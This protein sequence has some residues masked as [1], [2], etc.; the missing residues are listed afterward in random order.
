MEAD[1]PA[2]RPSDAASTDASNPT[3]PTDT[4]PTTATWPL[5]DKAEKS[6]PEPDTAEETPTWEP[7]PWGA[8]AQEAR[9]VEWA[10]WAASTTF[11]STGLASAYGIREVEAFRRAVRDTFL[12]VRKPPVKSADIRPGERFSTDRRGYD[13]PQVDLFLKVASIRLAAM[14]STDAVK[15]TVVYESLFGNTRKV[16]EAISDGVREAYPDAH[17]ECVAVGRAAAELIRSTD[18]LIVGGP[19]HRRRMTTDASRNRHISREKKAQAKGEPPRELEPEAEGPGLRE[20]FHLMRPTKGCRHAAAFATCLGSA[21]AGSAGHEIARK[22]RRHGY[23]LVKY[24]AGFPRRAFAATVMLSA[25][26]LS[27]P[28]LARVVRVHARPSTRPVSRN[29]R[30][31][32][33]PIRAGR[34]RTRTHARGFMAMRG[35]DRVPRIFYHRAPRCP[36]TDGQKGMAPC[37][38]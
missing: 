1:R 8:P 16:A 12:G 31:C 6:P 25:L 24:P 5:L 26:R 18:L 17:V 36:E 28:A 38:N 37:G 14:E 33:T 15:V 3:T 22:L 4:P 10:A 2:D 7:P 21:L 32:Q 13:K 20:W 29:F 27:S 9:L 30:R 35:A 34:A 11:P 23:E 19:T